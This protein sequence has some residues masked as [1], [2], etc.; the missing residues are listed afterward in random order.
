MTLDPSV[1]S[2]VRLPVLLA[3]GGALL[4]CGGVALLSV[5]VALVV[6]GVESIVAA[7]SVAYVNVRS[8]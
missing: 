3:I 4:I 6:A 8:R 7:Y 2:A 1:R 5:P